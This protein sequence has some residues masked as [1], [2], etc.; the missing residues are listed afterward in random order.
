MLGLLSVPLSIACGH[1]MN[2]SVLISATIKYME[3]IFCFQNKW[4]YL[5]YIDASGSPVTQVVISVTDASGNSVT[6]IILQT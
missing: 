2:A 1:P 3:N 5:F 4:V 6:G